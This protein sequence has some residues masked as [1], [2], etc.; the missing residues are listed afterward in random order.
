MA[1]PAGAGGTGTGLE[2]EEDDARDDERGA[3]DGCADDGTS[4]LKAWCEEAD[5]F[6]PPQGAGTD[7]RVEEGESDAR[8]PPD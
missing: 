6:D 2:L 4:V 3:Q 7:A 8:D 5:T 1:A